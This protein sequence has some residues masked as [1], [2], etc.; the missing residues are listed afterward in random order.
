MVRPSA[1]QPLSCLPFCYTVPLPRLSGHA[2]AQTMLDTTL[3]LVTLQASYA[4]KS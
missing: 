1:C 3:L 4:T 2:Q